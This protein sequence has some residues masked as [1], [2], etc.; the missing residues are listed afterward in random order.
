MILILINK[1]KIIYLD[2]YY[3]IG[4]DCLISRLIVLNS[5]IL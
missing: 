1:I 4:I 5:Y 3:I 2:I